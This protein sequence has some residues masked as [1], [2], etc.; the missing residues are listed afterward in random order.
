MSSDESLYITVRVGPHRKIFQFPQ[1]RLQDAAAAM[2]AGK[3]GP[4]IA[5]APVKW[6]TEEK[7][8][9]ENAAEPDQ[10]SKDPEGAE[11]HKE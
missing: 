4:G 1:L 6:E 5:D 8:E 10:T 3:N 7:K 9:D 11:G 2:K